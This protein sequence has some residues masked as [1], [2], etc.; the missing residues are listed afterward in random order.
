MA[1]PTKEATK[2]PVTTTPPT[3]GMRS[4][5]A[6]LEDISDELSRMWGQAWPLMPRPF[7]RP[8]TQLAEMPTTW[9]PRVDV[10]DQ[11]GEM[12]VKAELP[13]VKKDDVKIS[14]EDEALVIEG[15]RHA[16]NEVKEKDY[17]RMERSFGS[18]H[19]R[20]AMPAG[21]DADQVKASFTD[22]VL[23]VRIPKPAQPEAKSRQVPIN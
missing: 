11:N 19:R 8:L 12:V 7:L 5:L 22:G 16:E 3:A 10:F 17:Y 21:I 6:F 15:E 20:L 4:H 13:G 18:F 14:L 9:A 23:E 2:V 1:Q